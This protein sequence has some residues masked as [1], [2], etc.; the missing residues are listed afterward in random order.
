MLEF[1][2]ILW[3]HDHHIGNVAQIGK[4]ED[5]VMGWTILAYNAA[6]VQSKNHR[7][8]LE[9]NIVNNLIVGPLQK[10]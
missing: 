2:L 1:I 10:G 9:T 5:A 3:R 4:I 7:K 6:S 8:V